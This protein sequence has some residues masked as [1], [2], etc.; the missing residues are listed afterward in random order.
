MQGQAIGS[1]RY[2]AVSATV[3]NLK[4]L[5]EWLGVPPAGIKCFGEWADAQQKGWY[6]LCW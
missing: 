6:Y 3:P 2:V 4:D 5:A 1:V